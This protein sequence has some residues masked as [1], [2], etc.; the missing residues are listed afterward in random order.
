[1]TDELYSDDLQKEH[2]LRLD[3]LDLRIFM[4]E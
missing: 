2:N 3:H 4:I 1:M